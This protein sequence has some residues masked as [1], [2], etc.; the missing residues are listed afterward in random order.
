K[1]IETEIMRAPDQYLWAHRRF[2]TRPTGEASFY[3]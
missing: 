2:K 1:L 3:N